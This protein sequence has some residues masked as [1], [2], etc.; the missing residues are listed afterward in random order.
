[1]GEWLMIGILAPQIPLAYIVARVAV[2]RARQGEIPD[3]RQGFASLPHVEDS[4]PG[5]NFKSA[6]AAQAWFE[7]RRHGWSLPTWVAILLPFEL[8]LLWG[9]GASAA[10]A[11][12]SL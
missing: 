5:R 3:W 6:A 8:G 9:G 7:W 1:A 12:T 10:L 4:A 11:F 2:A